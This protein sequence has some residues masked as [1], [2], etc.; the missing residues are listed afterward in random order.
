MGR[1]GPLGR[2][3]AACV[4]LYNA[5]KQLRPAILELGDIA[6]DPSIEAR[7]RNIAGQVPGVIGLDKCFVRKMGLS[8]YADRHI[9]V[10]GELSV[11]EGHRIAHRVE[12]EVHSAL[13]EVS[14][15]LVHVEPE[16][17]LI[18]KQIAW[19]INNRRRSEHAVSEDPTTC[20]E[21][22]SWNKHSSAL[23]Q[24]KR[25]WPGVPLEQ[26]AQLGRRQ[27]RPR[28]TGPWFQDHLGPAPPA[29]L[30]GSFA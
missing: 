8:F 28:I 13:P 21:A 3:G 1:S 10:K 7:I 19:I 18:S 15:V 23:E 11:R 5:W 26:T 27:P 2:L 14:E 16:E 20:G 29:T 22:F 17:E 25:S 12:D 24:E 30:L 6:P 9:I 4:I